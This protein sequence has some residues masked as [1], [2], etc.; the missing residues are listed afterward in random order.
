MMPPKQYSCR[1]EMEKHTCGS[2]IQLG[3]LRP[4]GPNTGL[5]AL[6]RHS[7]QFPSH[8]PS[9][10]IRVLSSPL[11]DLIFGKE[12]QENLAISVFMLKDNIGRN[13]IGN[14]RWNFCSTPTKILVSM[15]K[16]C[17]RLFSNSQWMIFRCVLLSGQCFCIW[18]SGGLY[19]E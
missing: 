4:S 1:C 3:S 9:H 10:G 19:V 5:E 13:N 12:S 17:V 14:I 2:F 6:C 7:R 15:W 18:G 11:D 16:M 8:P